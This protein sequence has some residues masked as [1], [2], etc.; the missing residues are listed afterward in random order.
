MIPKLIHYCWLSDDEKP[1]IV[2]QCMETLD[3]LKEQGF[4]FMLWDRTKFDVNSSPYTASCWKKK[5]Y[6]FICDYVRVKALYEYGGIYL[7]CDV[8]MIKPF[9]DFILNNEYFLAKGYASGINATTMACEKN[10][11]IFKIVKEYYENNIL[12]YPFDT[13]TNC[14]MEQRM[15]LA[16]KDYKGLVLHDSDYFNP[17]YNISEHSYCNHM[18]IASW[19]EP[20]YRNLN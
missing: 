19:C 3:M 13:R 18:D 5:L 4:E 17:K 2:K 14:L 6:A 7:D 8:E 10:H 15:E 1:E 9:D 12:P 11:E 16:L 20:L